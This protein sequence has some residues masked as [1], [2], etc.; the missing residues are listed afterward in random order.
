MARKV[1]RITKLQFKAGQAK[2]GP[3]LAGLS[4]DMVGFT[5]EFNNATRDR[6]GDIVPVVITAYNDRSY[7]FEL[8][9]SPVASLLIKAAGITKGA[10][11]TGSEIVGSISLK[12]LTEI[13]EYKMKDLN[14]TSLKSAESMVRGT[15]KNMGITIEGE[16][17]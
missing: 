6:E 8:K 14:T 4:I 11:K 9:T 16:D 13:A 15:A 2:P 7:Q 17:K 10:K 3:E 12:Q 5:R 1:T